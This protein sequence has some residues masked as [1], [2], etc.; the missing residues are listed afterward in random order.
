[1]RTVQKYPLGKESQV[2][3]LMPEGGEVLCVHAQDLFAWV[4]AIVDYTKLLKPRLFF[5]IPSGSV[6]PHE[7]EAAGYRGSFRL[8]NGPESHV[9]EC[10]I[11]IVQQEKRTPC[12]TRYR[13]EVLAK[14]RTEGTLD[15]CREASALLE[16][17]TLSQPE[18]STLK[19][20]LDEAEAKLK[21][22]SI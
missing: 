15:A 16:H 8:E 17:G 10:L 14:L 13:E 12:P 7:A 5:I 9:F 4:W 21:H 2:I 22:P 1:M 6:L 18:W 3:L 19:Q 11:P 20:A